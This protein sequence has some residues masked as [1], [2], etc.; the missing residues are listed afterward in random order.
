VIAL[1]EY[2]DA[3]EPLAS[4]LAA[5]GY[6]LEV[7]QA[8]GTVELAV[9]AGPTACAECL[10]PK[11]VFLEV[12]QRHLAQKGLDSRAIHIAFPDDRR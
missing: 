9:L 4:L 6:I 5:D 2:E 10:V 7:N 1:N 3:L 12:A 8:D 11:D